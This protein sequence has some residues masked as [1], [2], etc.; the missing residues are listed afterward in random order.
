MLTIPSCDTDEGY[1]L[2]KYW[3]SL[4]TVKTNDQPAGSYYLIL[5]NRQKLWPAAQKFYFNAIEGERV[6]VNYTLL[7][8]Q[9]GD[10]DH[11]I[12]VNTISK[13]LLKTVIEL[14]QQNQDSIGNNPVTLEDVWLSGKYLNVMFG[15]WGSG[16]KTHYI[17]L[18]NNTTVA[19][20][21][22]NCIYLELR[23]NANG[24][25]AL[26]HFHGLVSFDLTDQLTGGQTEARFS[27]LVLTEAQG[28]KSFKFTADFV[29]WVSN[30]PSLLM[31]AIALKDHM[32]D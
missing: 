1:S 20:P 18:V 28:A 29:D 9:M 14:N 13:V 10:Y 26:R 19:H 31:S 30:S 32:L 25:S 4:A 15:Y 17:N 24:D 2:D 22:D 27:I 3:V 7:S 21:A 8:D 5:D 11:Y 6:L 16:H 23:H 12:R